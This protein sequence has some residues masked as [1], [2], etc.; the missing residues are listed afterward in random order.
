M[1]VRTVSTTDRGEAIIAYIARVSNPPNQANAS[2][3]ELIRYLIKH[4][5][6][7]PFEHAHL[8]IE[9]EC[10]MPIGEQLLRHQSMAFQKFSFRYSDVKKLN[11]QP[12]Y[13]TARI[14]GK[15]N[16]QSSS[17]LAALPTRL[18]FAILQRV[19]WHGCLAA[20]TL[21]LRA[22]VPREQARFLLPAMLTTR[23]YATASVRTWIHYLGLRLEADTQ[24]EHRDIAREI[25]VHFKRAYPTV[26][27]AAI[28]EG[29][30]VL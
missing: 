20:Y 13:T 25:W 1:R 24:G 12:S 11:L 23:L 28:Q 26:A 27:E 8:G 19:V 2:Y 21:A 22:G 14:P 15:K 10:S 5:H 3:V 16:R 29:A 18:L 9:V 30:I 7:S 6:W 4:K 17:G